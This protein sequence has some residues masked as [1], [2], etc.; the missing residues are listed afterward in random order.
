MA[1]AAW[2][3]EK[4]LPEYFVSAVRPAKVPPQDFSEGRTGPS[5]YHFSAFVGV[6]PATLKITLTTLNRFYYFM[7]VQ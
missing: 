4:S 2:A 3:V 6:I 5:A 1:Y 7:D